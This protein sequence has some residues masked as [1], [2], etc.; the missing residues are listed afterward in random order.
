M[1]SEAAS[2]RKW[3]FEFLKD[4]STSQMVWLPGQKPG[5]LGLD[6]GCIP[7]VYKNLRGGRI[8]LLPLLVS[9]HCRLLYA[10]PVHRQKYCVG[11]HWP[12]A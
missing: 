4:V 5:P 12:Q 11:V 10:D 1:G 2:W 6:K 8:P 3:H 7:V 9:Q